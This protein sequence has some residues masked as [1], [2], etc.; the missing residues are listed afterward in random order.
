MKFDLCTIDAMAANSIDMLA[1][2][3][4]SHDDTET[5]CVWVQ[6]PEVTHFT[7]DREGV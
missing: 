2:K 1:C 4:P 3:T 5:K 7:F 6:L